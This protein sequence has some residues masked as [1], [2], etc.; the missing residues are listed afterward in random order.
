MQISFAI[1]PETTKP[2]KLSLP[3]A[4]IL[5]YPGFLETSEADSNFVELVNETPLRHD[6]LK[7][8]GKIVPVP[9]LQAWH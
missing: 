2:E 3:D 5:F 9:R 7:F 1:G 4:E 6:S 8:G